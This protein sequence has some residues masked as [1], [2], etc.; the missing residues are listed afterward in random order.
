MANQIESGDVPMPANIEFVDAESM[1]PTAYG[2]YSPE[3]GGTIYLAERLKDKPELMLSVINE[4]LGHHF[5]SVHGGAD[6]SGDEG[7]IF[8]QSF[9][10]RAIGPN[11]A[12]RIKIG[13]RQWFYRGGW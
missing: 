9:K 13:A 2:A 11:S 5:D 10:L 7:A 3:N 6:A 4:E 8:A 1:G 12:N